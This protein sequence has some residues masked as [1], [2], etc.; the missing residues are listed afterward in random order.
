[1]LL[2]VTE[3]QVGWDD[4]ASDF[5]WD[6]TDAV[7]RALA[8]AFSSEPLYVDIRWA[9]DDMHLSRK[10]PRFM[11][12]V[13]DL[14]APLHHKPK[15]DMVGD[16]I[17]QQRRNA[18]W[19]WSAATV[20]AILTIVAIVGALVAVQQRNEARTQRA[21]A[22][23]RQLA[24]QAV[25]NTNAR[26]DLALLLALE[27]RHQTETADAE[28]ALFGALQQTA[29]PG[30]HFVRDGSIDTIAYSPGGT[31]IAAAS[32]SDG[33]ITIFELADETPRV[34]TSSLSG[35][36][37]V[38]F[39]PSGDLFAAASYDGDLDVWST[40][41]WSR[42]IELPRDDSL[43]RAPAGSG[44]AD[45]TFSPDGRTL[46][47]ALATGTVALWDVASWTIGYK[48]T[49][50][51]RSISNRDAFGPD[52]TKLAVASEPGGIWNVATR[53]WDGAPIPS[54]YETPHSPQTGD[55]WPRST[56][57]G[58]EPGRCRRSDPLRHPGHR[59]GSEHRR[60]DRVQSRRFVAG[61]SRERRVHRPLGPRTS[62]ESRSAIAATGERGACDGVQPRWARS[63]GGGIRRKPHPVGPQRP[64]CHFASIAVAA[65]R[66]PASGPLAGRTVDRRQRQPVRSADLGPQ[67]GTATTHHTG[68]LEC[69]CTRRVQFGRDAPGLVHR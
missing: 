11:D 18:R 49:T 23:S 31:S 65:Q 64:A 19:A 3:G 20:L 50:P 25:A 8:G 22:L 54:L 66:V 30:R 34:L 38:A 53:R 40:S 60:R 6:Q 5:A 45:I 24:A 35:V 13:A 59:A 46:A 2:V 10:N 17:R 27:A 7:P 58:S 37:A 32:R 29:I 51:A 9:T 68:R 36:S 63:R 47:T 16:G 12:V 43:T 15:D 67:A 41:D 42:V 33:A 52:G 21:Q 1:M 48:F 62:R 39:S 55:A 14:A 4:A 26:P 69:C 57:R 28:N 44:I 56:R 61:H